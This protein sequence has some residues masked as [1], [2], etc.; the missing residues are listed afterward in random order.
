[1][2]RTEEELNSEKFTVIKLY[3]REVL[4]TDVRISS[5]L[6]PSGMHKYEV[7]HDDECF[8]E[9]VQLAKG[10]MVNHWGT[11]IS[12]K[13]IKLDEDGYRDIDEERD[14]KD[15]NKPAITLKE[16]MNNV[17]SKDNIR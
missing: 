12:D 10:I 11:I 17:K 9:M 15:V 14:V 16:Y 5:S 13:P 3:G 7:R 8:G 4:F 2:I 6:I 1:M